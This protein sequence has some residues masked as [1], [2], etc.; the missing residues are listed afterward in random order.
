M[1]EITYWFDYGDPGTT[2]RVPVVLRESYQTGPNEPA[3]FD[4]LEFGTIP[5]DNL[6]LL[7]EEPFV[8]HIHSDGSMT[9]GSIPEED[10]DRLLDGFETDRTRQKILD[11]TDA[12]CSPAEILDYLMTEKVPVSQVEWSRRRDKSQQAINENVRKAR[13]NLR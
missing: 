3:R 13:K 4:N 8:D 7:D 5:V 9:W 11:L 10:M 12:G 1:T 2:D 6:A